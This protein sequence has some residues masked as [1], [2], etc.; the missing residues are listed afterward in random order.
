MRID[1]GWFFL[2]GRL[3][4]TFVLR[5]AVLPVRL[6]PVSSRQELGAAK[7]M[8]HFPPYN[9]KLATYVVVIP[10]LYLSS[11]GPAVGEL[12]SCLDCK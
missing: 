4:S 12:N 8:L 5:S 6:L 2:V 1:A 9:T 3:S 10:N 11:W 7:S